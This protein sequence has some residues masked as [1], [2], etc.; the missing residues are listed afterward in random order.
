MLFHA[1]FVDRDAFARFSGIG[2]GCQRLQ[3]THISEIIIGP[4]P[5]D[6]VKP[7]TT[8]Q[9]PAGETAESVTNEFDES[10]FAG[11][12]TIDD[13]EDADLY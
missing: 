6:P 4:D 9:V 3:S 13:N 11:C 10:R 8:E 7:S 2:I 1:R 5:P 12:Y